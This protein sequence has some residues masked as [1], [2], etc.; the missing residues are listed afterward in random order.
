MRSLVSCSLSKGTELGTFRRDLICCVIYLSAPLST[1]KKLGLRGVTGLVQSH[2]SG[3]TGK[4]AS[5][6]CL[7]KFWTVSSVRTGADYVFLVRR[8]RVGTQ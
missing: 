8:L 5:S 7:W 3:L 1:N 6:R 4:R 2:T